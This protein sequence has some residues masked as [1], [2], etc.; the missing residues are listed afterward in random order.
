MSKARLPLDP[1][2]PRSVEPEEQSSCCDG[3]QRRSP[4]A[5]WKPLPCVPHSPSAHR[6]EPL[7]VPVPPCSTTKPLSL[8]AR[9]S[10]N[11]PYMVLWVGCSIL[12]LSEQSPLIPSPITAIIPIP[13][14]IALYNPLQ[15]APSAITLTAF[16]TGSYLFSLISYGSE[17][18]F[19]IQEQASRVLSCTV[20]NHLCEM[21]GAF[22]SPS[23]MGW[24]LPHP[25]YLFNP[26]LNTSKNPET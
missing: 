24:K 5:E 10:Q 4:L 12:T 25:L 8:Q 26:L 3:Q 11:N 1:R 9:S 6:A 23:R 2:R 7:W 13:S 20:R 15:V 18:C 16:P 14:P 22:R 17:D 21:S 19:L